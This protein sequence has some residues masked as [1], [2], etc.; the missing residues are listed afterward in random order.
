MWRRSGL[1]CVVF[2]MGVVAILAGMTNQSLAQY[3]RGGPGGPRMARVEGKG[4]IT[5]MQGGLLQ[6]KDE[7]N[8]VVVL[9]VKAKPQNITVTGT[10]DKSVLAPGTLVRFSAELNTDG[11]GTKPVE[12]LTVFT[13]RP[14]LALGI[15]PESNLNRGAFQFGEV[16]D[17]D[18]PPPETTSYLVSGKIMKRSDDTMSV[19]DGKTSVQVEL[20]EAPEIKVDLM[21]DYRMVRAG[22]VVEFK[23][24]LF[25]PG[26]VVANEVKITG[27]TPFSNIAAK[28]GDRTAKERKREKP[29]K[30]ERT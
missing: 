8:N 25:Q 24:E 17:K 22:D 7:Q 20:S 13:L 19:S 29:A 30:K 6:I 28:G 27:A 16:A 4:E 10:A 9:Q 1:G 15:A 23:G 2:G 11:E 21:G 3:G 26:K 18:A 12:S 5:G 14:P